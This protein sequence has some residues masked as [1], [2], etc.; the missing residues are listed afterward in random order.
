M[1][2]VDALRALCAHVEALAPGASAGLTLING[3]RTH[4]G[5]AIFPSLPAAF[6]IA[7]TDVPLEPSGLGPV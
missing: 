7:L 3:S 5:E 1:K 2:D 4:I 6:S